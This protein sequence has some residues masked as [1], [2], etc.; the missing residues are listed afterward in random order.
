M[1]N[2]TDDL[3]DDYDDQPTG[4]QPNA[5]KQM[6][7]EL[8]SLQK[9]L[10]EASAGREEAEQLRRENLILRTPGLNTLSERQ[11]KALWATHD[12]ELN[13]D[14]LRSTA[15][16]LGFVAPPE[17]ATPPA[18]QAALQRIADA[19]AGA[20]STTQDPLAAVMTAQN[21]N[22]FWAAAEAVGRVQQ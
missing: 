5:I 7:S 20:D 17:P 2:H 1:S 4:D 3:D 21:E 13:T 16:E 22:E 14:A 12:G 15:Q 11:Q 10:R 9:Q 19:S 6:R 8:R 18:E